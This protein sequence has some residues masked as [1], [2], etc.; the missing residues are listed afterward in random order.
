MAASSPSPQGS[1]HHSAH[2][3]AVV[4]DN[5]EVQGRR[6]GAAK[7]P[8]RT[9]GIGHG[10]P[11]A[12]VAALDMHGLDSATAAS[13]LQQGS[14]STLQDQLNCGRSGQLL[15]HLLDSCESCTCTNL[16]A[17]D[18]AGLQTQNARLADP[19]ALQAMQPRHM[20]ASA[21]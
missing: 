10:D 1:S 7:L 3:L 5:L 18:A 19:A 8:G 6:R 11:G 13:G 4:S 20:H 2:L 9:P 14:K 16:K 12:A 21:G 15:T 17:G